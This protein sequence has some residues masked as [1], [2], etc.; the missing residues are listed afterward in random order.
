MLT[1]EIIR[2]LA[3]KAR[4]DYVAAFV[5][6]TATLERWG[7]TTPERVAALLATALHETGGLTIVRESMIYTTPSRIAAVWPSRFT[8]ASA[9]GFVRNEKKLANAVYGG[10]MGNE[11]N[12]TNDDDGFRYRGGGLPQLTGLD[13]YQACGAAIGVD[14]AGNPELIEDATVSLS[15]LCWEMSKF[16]QYCDLGERGWKAV[17]NGINRGSALSKLDPIGWSDRQIY[18]K[19]CCDAL[20]ATGATDDAMRMG[21]QGPLVKALQERLA[22]L[23]Y[24][25]GRADGIY[26]NRMRAAVLAFQ[27]EN[28]LTTDGNIGSQTR[29][30]LNSE[31]AKPMPLGE[32]ATETAADLKAAGSETIATA[33]AIKSA[34]K[35][36]L[37]VAAAGGVTQQA[38]APAPAPVDVIATTKDVVSEIGSWKAITSALSET[39][40]WVT[41]HWWVFAIVAAFA[42]YRWGNK[43]E[44]R[45]VITHR[46][47]LNLEH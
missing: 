35:G 22:A 1:E 2:S 40:A 43:I 23:G 15:A 11:R 12:G 47:G 28:G 37:G 16:T 17:C 3:P 31:T 5:N 41:S 36:I 46:L 6:G 13:S 39:F 42:F 24:A 25:T 21:D 29:N 14:L 20:G 8:L 32:R 7:F 10:R 26:G 45:R 27:A 19:R 33:Q 44:V 34:A 30:A 38:T 9:A 18:Y 4:A